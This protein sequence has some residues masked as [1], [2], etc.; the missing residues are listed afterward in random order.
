MIVW[1]I[2]CSVISVVFHAS[3]SF[4]IPVIPDHR[5]RRIRTR[6][7][8]HRRALRAA[9]SHPERGH[10]VPA[11]RLLFLTG[12]ESGQRGG[13]LFFI[14]LS[15]DLPVSSLLAYTARVSHPCSSQQQQQPRVRTRSAQPDSTA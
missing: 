3:L 4:P 10:I 9:S 2:I 12:G 15:G 14:M 7:L 8:L 11:T 1:L 5:C 13:V 6:C